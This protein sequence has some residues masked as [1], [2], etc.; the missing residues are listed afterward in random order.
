MSFIFS[1][2]K[3]VFSRLV[4]DRVSRGERGRKP[5]MCS[6]QLHTKGLLWHPQRFMKDRNTSPTYKTR[7][8]FHNVK[9]VLR[10]PLLKGAGSEHLSRLASYPRNFP[11]ASCCVEK[12]FQNRGRLLCVRFI[13]PGRESSTIYLQKEEPGGYEP[14]ITA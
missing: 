2:E 1:L 13:T 6:A 8:D 11:D 9:R 5:W 3:H 7:V 10:F 14:C 4:H 12:G